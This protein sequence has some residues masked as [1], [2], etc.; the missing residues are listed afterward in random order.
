[1][2]TGIRKP[3]AFG[4]RRLALN[5][6]RRRPFRTVCL[7]AAAMVLAFTLFG[8]SILTASLQ[9]GM[10]SLGARMGADMMVVPKGYT[11]KAEAVLL[12]GEP[13]SFYFDG[14]VA[15][16][17]ARVTGV[18]G[19]SSQSYLTSLNRSCC[20]LPV[21]M[22]GFDPDTDFVIRPWIEETYSAAIGDGQLVVG[23]AIAT[24]KR[25]SLMFFN[26]EYPVAAQLSRTAT[27]LDSTI[28]MTIPTMRSMMDNAR[29]EGGGLLPR[30]P[31]NS[32]S[33]ILVRIDKR[34]NPYTIAR[35]IR[36]KTMADDVEVI[37]ANRIMAGIGK[38]INGLVSYI[39]IFS[40]ILWLASLA[41]LAAIFFGSLNERKK[42]FA[43]LRIL[44][45]TRKKLV[46]LVV[47]ESAFVSLAGAAAGIGLACLVVFPFSAYI[48]GSLRLPYLPPRLAG[49]LALLG[50]S[51]SASF[52][53]GPLVSIFAA[54]KISKAETYYTLREGE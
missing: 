6:L 22:I 49:L 54:F 41:V 16:K 48:G 32:V 10:D 37:V 17:I 18:T 52:A 12:K 2:N 3:A 13:C 33:V 53:M 45:T 50:T 47:S 46:A 4:M 44:G 35:K 30:G 1:M 28:F 27:G 25:N 15:D 5:T 19:I 7:A 9:N 31:G 42:E 8:G 29:G 24:G 11:E 40:G 43:V 20:D 34:H 14:A 51:L 38:N 36:A 39:H 23:G 21:Q 26:H